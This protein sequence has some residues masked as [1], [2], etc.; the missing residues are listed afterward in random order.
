MKS[1][2]LNKIFGAVNLLAA[3]QKLFFGGEY[4]FVV[5]LLFL[6]NGASLLLR[7]EESEFL[8]SLSKTLRR[9]AL[10][11]AVTLIIKILFTG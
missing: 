11:V 6:I 1:E 10:A 8:Q 5:A 4:R 3:L 7:D 9:I 2:T